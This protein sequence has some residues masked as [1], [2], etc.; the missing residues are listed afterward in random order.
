MGISRCD[1][2]GLD[3]IE[4]QWSS[5]CLE[6]KR[7][8]K[9]PPDLDAL[10]PVL[11]AFKILWTPANDEQQKSSDAELEVPRKHPGTSSPSYCL[12]MLR[13]LNWMKI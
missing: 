3:V 2:S 5:K 4:M 8:V 13:G 6:L 9:C 11:T 10:L 12:L 7:Q 1:D